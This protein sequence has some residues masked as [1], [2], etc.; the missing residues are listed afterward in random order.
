MSGR[1]AE[2]LEA[3][4]GPGPAESADHLV[5]DEED[6]VAVAD[7]A[8]LLEV[9]GRGR[10]DAA[11]TDDRLGD[12]GADTVGPLLFDVLLERPRAGEPA[13]GDRSDP[14]RSGSSRGRGCARSRRP[15]G[16]KF[17]CM[18]MMP[19]ADMVAMVSPWYPWWRATM[20]LRRSSPRR[21]QYIRTSLKLLSLAS[22]PPD[23]NIT[24]SSPS[25]GGNWAAIT[26]ASSM[27]FGWD[28][29]WKVVK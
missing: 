17:Q 2:V 29:P 26:S 8:D 25:P 9:A 14:A 20:V 7:P 19:V 13:G 1:V 27:A 3:E 16:P 4:A 28:W 15:P 12:E 22:D 18:G 21:A 24:W 23:A 11:G 5:G 6:V 10:N